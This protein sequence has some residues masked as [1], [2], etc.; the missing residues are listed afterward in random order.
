MSYKRK[1]KSKF[2]MLDRYLYQS[3]AWR[4]SSPN[5]RAA[6]MELK[7]AYDGFNNGRIGLSVRALAEAINVGKNAAQQAL[8]GLE[9]KGFIVRTKRSGFSVKNRTATEWRLTEYPCDVTGGQASKEFMRWEPEEKSTVPFQ[10]RT[11]PS[12]VQSHPESE[13]KIA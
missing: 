7:T 3:K 6:Y 5:E 11:V 1:G 10:V 8:A 13:A 12:Q 4:A 2:L 9:A